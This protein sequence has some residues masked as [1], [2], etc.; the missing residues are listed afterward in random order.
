[1]E[2]GI[3]TST[4]YVVIDYGSEDPPIII[5]MYDDLAHAEDALQTYM[6]WLG[7][8]EPR[9]TAVSLHDPRYIEIVAFD[10]WAPWPTRESVLKP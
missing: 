6:H 10:W 9:Y 4:Q 2:G 8:S 1:V 3:V 5:A 7:I